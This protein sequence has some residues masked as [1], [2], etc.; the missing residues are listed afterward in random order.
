LEARGLGAVS[1]NVRITAVRKLAVEAADNG[2]LAPELAAGIVRVKGVASKGV[3]LGNW[4]SVKQA[5]MLLNTPD[6]TRWGVV[7]G[8]L[9]CNVVADFDG[10]KG[11]A[12]M[13][14]WGINPHLR[15]GSGGFHSYFQH[16]G[17][18]VPTLNAKS[19]TVEIIEALGFG[20]IVGLSIR[21][22]LPC[23]DPEPRV[24]QT[25]KLASGPGRQPDR[26]CADLTLKKEFEE[27][28]DQLTQLV[29]AVVDIEV[30]HSL[31]FKIVR[32]RKPVRRPS[33]MRCSCCSA[34]AASRA[35]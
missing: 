27:L 20:V 30:Q 33:T 35:F 8:R 9:A 21:D 31:P 28:F 7:T 1:I 5:Q 6:V 32:M 10:E 25:I 16:P 19:Q 15:T 34:C 29:N 11:I 13:Q 2:L 3:R 17:W 4:L 24:V 14:K 23:Y 22:G 26:S 12:L 18:R